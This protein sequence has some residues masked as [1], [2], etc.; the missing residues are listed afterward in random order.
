[1]KVPR[2]NTSV[3]SSTNGPVL[4]I[5]HLFP[6]LPLTDVNRPSLGTQSLTS[7]K[8]SCSR[9]FLPSEHP[10][11]KLSKP[12]TNGRRPQQ[13]ASGRKERPSLSKSA[14]YD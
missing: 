12:L 4:Q 1:M 3:A 7:R 9:K 6:A 14:G 8:L 10:A 13:A 11:E 2:R 5:L